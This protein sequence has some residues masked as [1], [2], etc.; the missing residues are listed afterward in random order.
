M[1]YEKSQV[2]ALEKVGA[3]IRLLAVSNNSS[4]PSH[5]H[6]GVSLLFCQD[7]FHFSLYLMGTGLETLQNKK[8]PDIFAPLVIKCT[9]AH[10]CLI[11]CCKA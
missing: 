4:T 6:V 8:S 3:R 7:S 5:D 2:Q 10:L 11:Y 9:L 1:C